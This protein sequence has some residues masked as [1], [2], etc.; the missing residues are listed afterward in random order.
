MKKTVQK[1]KKYLKWEGS[2]PQMS[3]NWAIERS[4]FLE[5]PVLHSYSEKNRCG[6]PNSVFLS[7][8]HRVRVPILYYVN[9][10]AP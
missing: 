6:L 7:Q 8:A 4:L 5:I 3:N 1:I 9:V 10:T 2:N